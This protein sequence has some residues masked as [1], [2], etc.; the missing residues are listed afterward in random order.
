M[1]SYKNNFSL[2]VKITVL[3]LKDK[4]C[5]YSQKHSLANMML[6]IF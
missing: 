4:F 6:E 2:M 1:C 5:V 3:L